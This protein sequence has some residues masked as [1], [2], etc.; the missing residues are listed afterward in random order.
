MRVP[1]ELGDP[2]LR[3]RSGASHGLPAAL[4]KP[5]AP[6][7]AVANVAAWA[8]MTLRIRRGPMRAGRR[9]GTIR[10]GKAADLAFNR[11][12]GHSGWR[13]GAFDLPS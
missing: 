8:G 12:V 1:A 3:E 4:R 6:A 13:Q 9:L 11:L 7:Q 10:R 5:T 2:H